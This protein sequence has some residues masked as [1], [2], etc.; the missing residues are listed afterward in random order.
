MK[1]IIYS[2]FCL[3]ASLALFTAC[4]EDDGGNG[5]F[6]TSSTPALDVA[7]I[8]NG[9]WTVSA[10]WVTDELGVEPN[11]RV[12]IGTEKGDDVEGVPMDG[13]VVMRTVEGNNYASDLSVIGKESV[14][15]IDKEGNPE[16]YE[17]L[18]GD[19]TTEALKTKVN[20][21]Q[22]SNG[23]Y[24]LV[25]KV[26]N[27]DETASLTNTAGVNGT[28]KDGTLTL[29]FAQQE[30]LSKIAYI[31]DVVNAAYGLCNTTSEQRKVFGTSTEVTTYSYSFSGK[32]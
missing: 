10:V 6:L 3:F 4:S 16:T 1:K 14:Q 18:E 28:I 11:K 20:I 9:T 30:K 26:A 29:N 24:N 15:G 13:E 22:T 31:A 5:S 27:S 12:L 23:V 8:Y 19:E 7:G 2:G 17:P 32:E 21:F 25:N